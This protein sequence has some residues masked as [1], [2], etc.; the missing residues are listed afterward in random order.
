MKKLLENVLIL[1]LSRYQ[2]GPYGTLILA[3][4]GA[5]VIKIENPKKGDPG[6][7]VTAYTQN[8]FDPY[9][10][11]MNRNKKSLTLDIKQEQGLTTFYELV[12]KADVVY[13]NYR[14]KVPKS[15][16]IDYETL[17]RYNPKIISCHVTGFG[18]YG[19]YCDL[20][21]FDQIVQAMGGG[22]SLTGDPGGM[23][24][25]MGLAIGDAAGGMFAAHGVLA[26]L[27]HKAMTGEGQEIDIAMLDCQVSI[28]AFAPQIYLASG[29]MP[30]P[31]G[32]A[33]TI[34]GACLTVKTMDERYL[35]VSAVQDNQF[36]GFCKIIGRED[37]AKD[38]RFNS[39]DS[40]RE[41]RDEINRII[42][43]AFLEK[44]AE[45]WL[46][47]LRR[48]SVPCGPINSVAQVVNDP[49]LRQREMMVEVHHPKEGSFPVLGNPIKCSGMMD[50]IIGPPPSLG[51]HTEEILKEFLGFSK[52]DLE[53]L[54][55]KGII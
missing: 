32:S 37:L 18:H 34:V 9:F 11:S 24:K 19:P 21:A 40:R 17:K 1:D 55:S 26:A 6:R 41:N 47:V 25:L 42:E 29:E 4:L 43:E 16:K 39:I 15:L 46:S 50:S 49:H 10:I 5:E 48:E 31:R 52:E 3:D 44:T 13:D 27:Y 30:T 14:P 22:M 28:S 45:E 23:P 35:F 33:D 12:K 7:K 38:P 8:S 54:K 51:Q 36:E 53:N 2:A 20:P